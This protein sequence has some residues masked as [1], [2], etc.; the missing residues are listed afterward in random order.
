MET[1]EFKKEFERISSK[2]YLATDGPAKGMFLL[3]KVNIRLFA[4][5]FY[6]AGQEKEKE[7]LINTYLKGSSF[8]PLCK[9]D[10]P[11]SIK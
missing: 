7:N 9:A 3:N 8:C 5:G 4:L 1:P 11:F 6:L 10:L 2:I